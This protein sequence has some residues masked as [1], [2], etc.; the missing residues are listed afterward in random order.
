MLEA[1]I[2]ANH[3]KLMAAMEASHE[4]MMSSLEKTEAYLECKAP[5]SEEMESR[6]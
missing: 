1:K 6:V 3:K 5:T 4:K 2:E